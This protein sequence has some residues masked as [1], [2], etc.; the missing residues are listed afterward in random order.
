MEKTE[1]GL[2]EVERK[3]FRELALG[4]GA[5]AVVVHEGEELYPRSLNFE[6]LLKKETADSGGQSKPRGALVSTLL[7]I[8]IIVAVYLV[9][10]SG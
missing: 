9:M 1:G 10:L 6:A 2:T 8:V 3:A 5:R 7:M 4:A